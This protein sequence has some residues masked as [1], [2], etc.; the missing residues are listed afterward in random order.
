MPDGGSATPYGG[1]YVFVAFTV[2]C[3]ESSYG[4][5]AWI[6]QVN[7]DDATDVSSEIRIARDLWDELLSGLYRA[8]PY[9][10]IFD[11]S[12]ETPFELDERR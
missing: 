1:D 6:F 4:N 12:T 7:K 11:E 8:V 10:S 3:K 2:T 9:D 5:F